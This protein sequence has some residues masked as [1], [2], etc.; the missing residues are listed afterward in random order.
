VLAA[1][2]AGRGG[3]SFG[4]VHP[5]PLEVT[6]SAASVAV[7][8][9]AARRVAPPGRLALLFAAILVTSVTSVALAVVSAVKP[10][11]P[12]GDA[13]PGFAAV[14]PLRGYAWGFFTFAGVQ[15][16][17]GICAAT[18]AIW[19][20]TPARGARWATVGGALVW[21]G[22]AA[23]AVGIG[24]WAAVYYFGSD[25]RLGRAGAGLID[26]FNHDGAHM[27]A[28]PIGGA[29]LVTVG[30]LLLAVALWR[31]RSVPRWIPVLGAL[32]SLATMVLPPDTAA[33]ILAEAASSATTIPIGWYAWRRA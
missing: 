5:T 15:M 32:S 16:V 18:L 12:G 26:R 28:V 19:L 22:A 30:V 21:L 13:L 11:G 23:Y 31:A 20:L 7:P 25:P 1:K 10:I 3:H 14:S 2:T 33:G 24:G 17:V 9:P 8:R 29:L 27:M 4:G 6:V